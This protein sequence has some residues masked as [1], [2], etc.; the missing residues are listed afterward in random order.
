MQRQPASSKN[1]HILKTSPAELILRISGKRGYQ[2]AHVQLRP[3]MFDA[4]TLDVEVDEYPS[5]KTI[6]SRGWD[7]HPFE[8]RMAVPTFTAFLD[9]RD[10]GDVVVRRAELSRTSKRGLDTEFGF[11]LDPRWRG[12]A[13]AA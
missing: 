3:G 8:R 2:S 6:V 10:L 4:N 11:H 12:G 13:A 7:L 1:V 9:G 5:G